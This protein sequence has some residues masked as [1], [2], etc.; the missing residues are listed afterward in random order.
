MTRILFFTGAGLSAESGISTFRDNDDG[1]WT[2]YDPNVVCNYNTFKQ[3]HNVI[4]DFYD[5]RRMSLSDIQPNPA[6]ALIARIQQ[7]YPD[8]TKIYTMNIDDLLEKAGCSNVVHVHGRYSDMQCTSCGNVWDIGDAQWDRSHCK[9]CGALPINIKPGVVFFGE[10]APEYYDMYRTFYEAQ[11]SIIIVI[12]TSGDVIDLRRIV[13]GPHNS[14]NFK[15]LVNKVRH[16]SDWETSGGINYD[17]FDRVW[18]EPAT[19]AVSKI[20][21]HIDMLMTSVPYYK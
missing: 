5:E 10:S 9:E 12:G 14:T 15:M 7:K 18:I 4:H 19:K 17:Y 2:R 11:N 1:L 16:P 8:H 21:S 20:E 6:H 3:H 13:G